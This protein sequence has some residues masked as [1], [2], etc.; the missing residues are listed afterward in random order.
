M[1]YR[2]RAGDALKMPNE[3]GQRGEIPAVFYGPEVIQLSGG[4][5]ETCLG[6]AF[7]SFCGNQTE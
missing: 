3:R 7:A 2:R 4:R 5:L 1:G 6:L